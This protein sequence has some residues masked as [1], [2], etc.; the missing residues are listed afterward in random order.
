MNC[1]SSTIPRLCRMSRSWTKIF[2]KKFPG[3]SRKARDR[4]AGRFENDSSGFAERQKLR[5]VSAS[6]GAFRTRTKKSFHFFVIRE[7][8]P[9]TRL[10]GHAILLQLPKLQHNNEEAAMSDRMAD[11]TGLCR[12]LCGSDSLR[13]NKKAAIEAARGDF[14]REVARSSPL[15]GLVE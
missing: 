10:S 9:A 15:P 11:F 6:H 4:P 14:P 13:D 1:T 12:I 7:G 8:V 2:A 5:P 3:F